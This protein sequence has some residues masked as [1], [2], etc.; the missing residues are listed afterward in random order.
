MRWPSW[1]ASRISTYNSA[2]P[3]GRGVLARMAESMSSQPARVLN[4][5]A[6][7]KADEADMARQEIGADV[8]AY[9]DFTSTVTVWDPDPV[10]AEE[11]LQ[12]VMQ[13]FDRQGFVTTAE[14]HHAT[15]AWLSSHPGNRRDNV[16]RTPQPSLTLSH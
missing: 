5:D 1:Q 10:Q 3:Q 16:R 2:T 12:V 9:G 15:A 11:K 14:R 6:T 13:A 7:N 4:T 8:V